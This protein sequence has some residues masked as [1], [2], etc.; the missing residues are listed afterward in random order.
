VRRR[1]TGEPE[2]VER[3]VR[4]AVRDVVAL[5]HLFFILNICLMA[6]VRL[7]RAQLL[8]LVHSMSRWT[9]NDLRQ[10]SPVFE[11]QVRLYLKDL[12]VWHGAVEAIGQRHY[13]AY[14]PLLP[15]ARRRVP[16]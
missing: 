6:D 15:E 12:V 14:A 11:E 4:D 7:M 13:Q 8:L 1:L 16:E 2:K 9:R 3:A 5:W 10:L